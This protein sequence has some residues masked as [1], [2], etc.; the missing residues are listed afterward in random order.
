MEMIEPAFPAPW[1]ECTVPKM[2]AHAV[3]TRG[4]R[5]A[6]LYK[7]YGIWQQ[8]TWREYGERARLV[9]LGMVRLGFKRGESVAILSETRHEWLYAD[10]AAQWLGGVSLGIYPT[11]SR[12]QCEYIITD[13]DARVVFVE[14]EEQLDKILERLDRLPNL[15]RIVVFDMDGLRNFSH[16]AVISF[17]QLLALGAEQ[18][19][20][21][22]QAWERLLP[23]AQP[24][25]DAIL[26]YT[27]GTTGA[28]KGARMKHVNLA[29]MMYAWRDVAPTGPN[30][31]TL[32][33]LP[34]CHAAER[35]NT[36]I[37][38]LVYE[39]VVNF[40]ESP[41]TIFENL[42]E[43]SPT[44]FLGVPRIWEKL[45]STT[46]IALK[47][48]TPLQRWVYQKAIRV[49]EAVATYRQAKRPVPAGLR[50][51][52]AIAEWAA[53][54]NT[55]R[56]LGLDRCR[57][58]GSGAAPISPDA[59]RWYLALG[60]DFMELYGQ[61]ECT[62]V[63]TA[64]RAEPSQIGTVGTPVRGTEVRIA[65]D[66]EILIR[67]P[68]VFPGYRN[69][70][71]KT[72]DALKDG[73]LHT[74]DIGVIDADGVL[75]ITDR[76]SDIMI[77]SGGKNITPTEIENKLKFSPYITDAIVVAD[78][79]KYVT[80]LIMIDQEIV[81]NFALEK[82]ISFT[83]FASLTRLPEVRALIGEEVAKVNATLNN[84]EAIKKFELLDV[85]L[86]AEDD[87]MTPTLKLR[88]KFVYEKYRDLIN[89]MYRGS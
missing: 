24:D 45:Y 83:D 68:G 39:G 49:G 27:S 11:S 67:G 18:L 75:H 54:G 84:V 4:D 43:V 38:P 71:D 25:D 3:A 5:V 30:D 85:L 35:L 89:G 26:V 61:T 50:I 19:K 44:V 17:E 69:K 86:T 78:G 64:T 34:L 23:T 74:G 73:W 33:F 41:D 88:R 60:L 58:I 70:P 12:D 66:G 42:R 48:A 10:M 77:T 63:A 55:K 47:E 7:D 20:A 8:V 13:S 40:A 79:R 1:Q 81:E 82:R 16:E 80:C 14:D 28:P 72:A 32:A 2:F 52:R 9:G 29:Y 37:R 6:M 87:E 36:A 56:M 46:V 21:D 57:L 53:L 15:S 31:H 62:G 76:K 22:P 59:I 51:L 65:D